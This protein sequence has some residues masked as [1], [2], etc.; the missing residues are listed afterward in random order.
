MIKAILTKPLNGEPEGSPGEFNKTDFEMLE[1]LGAVKRA[2]ADDPEPEP[3]P[4]TEQTPTPESAPAKAAV[5]PANK[6]AVAPANKAGK[7]D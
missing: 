6:M 2:P 5:V 4:E 7:A 3:E 1:Q